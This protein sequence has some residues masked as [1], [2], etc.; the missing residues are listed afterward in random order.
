MLTFL[1][2]IKKIVCVNNSSSYPYIS[3]KKERNERN[4]RTEAVRQKENI[5]KDV[6]PN[7]L[8]L[9]RKVFVYKI[10]LALNI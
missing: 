10:L 8:P 4:E 6:V 2:F 3:E 5:R 7:T 1:L 9:A